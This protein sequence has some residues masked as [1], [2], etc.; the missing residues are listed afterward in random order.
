MDLNIIGIQ[1]KSKNSDFSIGGNRKRQCQVKFS[2]NGRHPRV[3]MEKELSGKTR[4]GTLHIQKRLAYIK[5]WA[6][7]S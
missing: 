1:A 2:R 3:F 7:E 6:I 5:T 4:K